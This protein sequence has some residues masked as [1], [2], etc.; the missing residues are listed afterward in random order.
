[1]SLATMA[2]CWA[3]R[4]MTRSPLPLSRPRKKRSTRGTRIARYGVRLGGVHG[5]QLYRLHV[6]KGYTPIKIPGFA[7][8][9]AV[10]GVNVMI[11]LPIIRT[12]VNRG[13]AF[14]I[15]GE[16]IASERGLVDA[17]DMATDN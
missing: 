8:S 3:A 12:S 4:T 5:I 9:D 1:M 14:D 6:S 17:V 16:G 11:G 10:F 15:A 13:T 2:A 7:G